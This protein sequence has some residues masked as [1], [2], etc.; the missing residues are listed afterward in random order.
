VLLP[1]L[2]LS[3]AEMARGGGDDYY[4]AL[5]VTSE[6]SAEDIKRAFQA[7]AKVLHPDLNEGA[8]AAAQF[9]RVKEAY[10]V[11]RDQ[12]RRGAYDASRTYRAGSG[13]YFQDDPDTLRRRGEEFRARQAAAAAAGFEG[14]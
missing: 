10:D 2:F 8:G 7:L 9:Q 3:I 13:Q 4:R 1:G 12:G 5:G 14:E 6:A 11:L